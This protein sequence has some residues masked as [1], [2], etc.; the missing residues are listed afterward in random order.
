M[1]HGHK[2]MANLLDQCHEVLHW[3][4]KHLTAEDLAALAQTCHTLNSYTKNNHLLWKHVYLEEFDDPR[5]CYNSR[6][7]DWEQE[8]K[9][10]TNFRKILRS[11]KASVKND[12]VEF[13]CRTSIQLVLGSSLSG[14]S[15][16][17]EILKSMFDTI[18][19]NTQT[20][21]HGSRLYEMTSGSRKA[22]LSTER[23]QLIAH[24][25]CLHGVKSV[26]LRLISTEDAISSF[27]LRAH[28][29]ARSTVYDLENYTS[30]NKWGPFSDNGDMNVDWEKV[31]AIMVDLAYN[32]NLYDDHTGSLKSDMRCTPFDGVQPNSY[33]TVSTGESDVE[34]VS[35]TSSWSASRESDPLP[36]QVD[37]SLDALDPYGVTGT[38]ERVVCFLDYNDFVRFNFERS[39]WPS[40]G[41]RP[42]V[43]TQEA[44]RLI[45][46]MVKVTKIEKPG[47]HDGKDLPIVHFEGRSC[48][49]HMLWDPNANSRL[50]G[51]V[52][53][54]YLVVVLTFHDLGTVRLTPKGDV[55]WATLSIFQG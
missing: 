4:F 36:Q 52:P 19:R 46:M 35:D 25:H 41:R 8:I 49:M 14:E 1:V 42:P 47:E 37:P 3:I 7:P 34:S 24:L 9:E 21:I 15:K 12:N 28:P 18:N 30:E 27:P 31:E 43:H 20:F 5:D 54:K 45:R 44:L 38:W 29:Y 39:N 48:S 50:T 2:R 40:D 55:R 22:P 33:K 32:L 51:E 23:S 6:Q 11:K 26:E 10:L 16:N 53:I 13:V 17:L